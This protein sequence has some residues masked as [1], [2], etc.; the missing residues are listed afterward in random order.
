V[1]PLGALIRI[2]RRGVWLP[3]GLHEIDGSH[4]Y[5]SRGIGMEGGRAPRVRFMCRPEIA[6]IDVVPASHDTTENVRA[7]RSVPE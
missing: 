6:V 2:H 4:L 5:V 7:S 1:P 3:A